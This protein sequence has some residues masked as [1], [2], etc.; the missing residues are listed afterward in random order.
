MSA[1]QKEWWPADADLQPFDEMPVGRD[2]FV[3]GEK[4]AETL[5][6]HWERYLAEPDGT[7]PEHPNNFVNLRWCALNSIGENSCEV[8]ICIDMS[9]R[10][11]GVVRPLPRAEFVACVHF[12]NYA[13][14]RYLVVSQK[15][16][17]EI[18]RTMFSLYSLVD[19][20]GMRDL[21]DRQGR[22]EPEQIAR[23]RDGIDALASE[24]RDHAF[25]SL[26]DNVIVKTNWSAHGSAYAN[27]YRPEHFL[28]IVNSVRAVFESALQLGSYAVV[29]Q[30]ANGLVD[31]AVLRVSR[32][33]NHVFFGSLGTPFAD[34]F[35]I[36]SAVR[37]ALREKRHPPT[38]LYLSE[39]FLLTLRFAHWE[40]RDELRRRLVPYLH[41][42]LSEEPLKYLPVNQAELADLM[43]KSGRSR[44]AV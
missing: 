19:A 5:R 41:R 39:S 3:I 11:H 6:L 27:T 1:S 8:N 2:M 7:S 13:K 44:A 34:L 28:E 24:H 16:F 32:E 21:L 17:D 30:G 15:W 42:V 26:A 33:Q 10:F 37:A 29:T 12:W 38:D 40:P 36:D 18:E 35:Y 43:K 14:R 23:L 4:E 9:T 22:I 31:D 20:I 25:I